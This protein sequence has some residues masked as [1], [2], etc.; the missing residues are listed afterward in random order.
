MELSD[1]IHLAYCTNIHPG[2][3]WAETLDSLNRHTLRVRDAVAPGR[4]FAIGLRLS[5]AASEELIKP[6]VLRAFKRWLKKNACYVFTINGFPYGQFHQV[7]VKEQVYR[8]DWTTAERLQYT[9]RLFTIL[10]ELL[11]LSPPGC[12]G[13]V[14]TLPG[15]FKPFCLDESQE[16]AIRRN[17]WQCVDHIETLARAAGR[18]LHLGLEPE[19]FGLF[20]TTPETVLFFQA[21]AAERPGD[22]RWRLYAGV[23]FDVCHLACQYEDPVQSLRAFCASGIRI[24]KIH[25]SSALRLKPTPEAREALRPFVDELYLHQVTAKSARRIRSYLDLD[26]ALRIPA[27]RDETEWRVH[28]H[29]PLQMKKTRLFGNTSSANRKVLAELGSHP[30]LC[31]HL[32]METYTWGV[33]P[34]ELRSGDVVDQ[35]AAEYAWCFAQLKSVGIGTSGR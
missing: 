2:E 19:P 23:N 4:P 24:S 1:G 30:T 3:T 7:R 6:A 35:L 28:F 29:V 20:E 26:Q 32:E 8:P 22:N 25:L 18:D 34:P 11:E 12:G 5:N 13:S 17:L 31:S 27:H 14:S 21:L 15:S 33:L 16:A 9:R 10:A